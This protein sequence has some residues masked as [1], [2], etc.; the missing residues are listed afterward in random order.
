MKTRQ[1]IANEYYNW[2]KKHSTIFQEL[3]L[4]EKKELIIDIVNNHIKSQGFK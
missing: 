1:Q 2:F 4:N 3:S